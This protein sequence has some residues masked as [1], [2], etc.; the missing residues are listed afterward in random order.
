MI[1]TS[2]AGIEEQ[3][4]FL[5]SAMLDEDDD[6]RDSTETIQLNTSHENRQKK[7]QKSKQ[8][9]NF[10]ADGK[11]DTKKRRTGRDCT[12]AFGYRSRMLK[13]KAEELHN[14]TGAPVKI[15]IKQLTNAGSTI[16][17]VYSSPN[18]TDNYQPRKVNKQT[19]CNTDEYEEET[20]T[21][22]TDNA[23]LMQVDSVKM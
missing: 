14:I 18:F 4:P 8:R 19:N 5:S 6:N 2:E 3:L 13:Q 12:N 20:D 10:M 17:V 15:E 21:T 23:D 9:R 22:A 1:N 11:I 16:P 7:K